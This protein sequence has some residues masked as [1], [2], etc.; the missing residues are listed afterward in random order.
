ME[1]VRVSIE[2]LEVDTLQQ[3]NTLFTAAEV[4][5]LMPSEGASEKH[6]EWISK[7]VRK[8]SANFREMYGGAY[9]KYSRG[10][11]IAEFRKK[12]NMVPWDVMRRVLRRLSTSWESYFSLRQEFACSY[13]VLCI[14]HWLL[15]IGDRH[16][17]NFLVSLRDGRCVGID[18]GYAFGMATQF[19]PVPELMPFRLTPH[20]VALLQP[21][22]ETGLFRETMIHC[23]RALR[24]NHDMLLAT[25]EVFVQEPTMD[26]LDLASKHETLTKDSHEEG[27]QEWYP[28]QKLDLARQK[29]AGSNPVFITTKELRAGF[30]NTEF[31]PKLLEAVRGS[32]ESIRSKLPSHNLSPENQVDCLLDQAMDYN[33]LGK[34][35]AGWD[36]WVKIFGAKRDEVTGEWRKL[37]NTELYTFYSSPGIIRNIKSRRLR[38]AGHVAHMGESRNAYR[39]LVGRPEGKKPLGRP[40]RRWEGNIKMDLREVGYDDRE[41]INLAQDRDQLRAYVRAAMNLRVP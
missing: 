30:S 18:F 24:N 26:W 23:L 33:I 11:T 5:S 14:A 21:L 7:S 15:G 36:P 32:D 4:R 12:V 22:E 19:L 37:H 39:V 10:D 2:R 25:M 28:K 35:W 13:A 16:L 41:W 29:L 20:I 27:T 1:K 34:T 6:W 3:H 31:L 17:S 38:W 8:K 40:R 9:M